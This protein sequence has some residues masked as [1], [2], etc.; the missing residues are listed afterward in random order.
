MFDD[1]KCKF[2]LQHTISSKSALPTKYLVS[3]PLCIHTLTWFTTTP[4]ASIIFNNN[5][6][7][8]HEVEFAHSSSIE[9]KECTVTERV[10]GQFICNISSWKCCC[11][12][13]RPS[14]L[15]WLKQ[16]CNM[17]QKTRTLIPPMA[18]AHLGMFQTKG[19]VPTATNCH[20]YST[21]ISSQQSCR[22][23]TASLWQTQDKLS[24]NALTYNKDSIPV[25]CTPSI[26]FCHVN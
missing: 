23:D 5:S 11:F 16:T 17:E 2:M 10:L 20:R 9:W 1:S 25:T 24:A 12:F 4:I 8:V 3:F 26:E 7:C 15:P 22:L 18:A 14:W 19:S 13:Q 21:N 6:D